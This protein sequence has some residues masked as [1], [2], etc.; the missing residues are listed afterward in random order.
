[1]RTRYQEKRSACTFLN[2]VVHLVAANGFAAEMV[3]CVDLCRDTQANVEL[4]EYVRDEPRGAQRRTRLMYHS[5]C[6]DIAGVLA[7]LRL[8]A[9]VNCSDARG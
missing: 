6:G 8:R 3:R 7:S 9:S 2:K 4:M 1:M 5:A